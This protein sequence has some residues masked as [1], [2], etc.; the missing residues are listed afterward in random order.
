MS[1]TNIKTINNTSL[2]GSGDIA[3]PSVVDTS[4]TAPTTGLVAGYTYFDTTDGKPYWYD[5][6]QFVDATGAPKV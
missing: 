5:G 3:I 4:A 2:L 1:G 6:T